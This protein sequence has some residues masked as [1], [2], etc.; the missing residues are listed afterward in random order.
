MRVLHLIPA[1]GMGGAERQLT[2]L[3]RELPRHG[4]DVHVASLEGGSFAE[5]LDPAT[6][7][8]LVEVSHKRDLSTPMRLA[9]LIDRV[10]PD[11]VQTWLLKMDVLGGLAARMRSVP[12]IATERN[13]ALNYPRHWT[14]TLRNWLVP[15]ADALVANSEGG[16]E[17]WHEA[18]TPAIQRIIRNGIES[19]PENA[20]ARLPDGIAIDSDTSVIVYSG[21]LVA[22]KRLT[23][24]LRA[25]AQVHR[26]TKSVLMLCGVGPL[27]EELR[28]LARELALDGAVIFTGFVG[29]IRAVKRRADV[30]VSMS[31][32]EGSPNA[33]QEAMA[34]GTPLVLSDIPGHRELVDGLTALLVDGND[35]NAAAAAI[36]A[37][38]RDRESARERAARAQLAAMAWSPAAMGA[39]YDALYRQVL[40]ARAR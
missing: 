26:E 24:L 6:T 30:M 28:R 13:S 23:V 31:R 27:E 32:F 14:T 15:S 10:K 33:V 40:H 36:L 12:W 25:F 34:C 18:G 5:I 16:L 1:L 2:L 35:A 9:R 21:R 39:D 19:E 17:M 37:C 22:D 11:V 7:L 29:D 4:W 8:H 3:S 20:E 38:L